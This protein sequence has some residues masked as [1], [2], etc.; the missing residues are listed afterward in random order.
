MIKNKNFNNFFYLIQRILFFREIRISN[1]TNR[2]QFKLHL[3]VTNGEETIAL[4][5]VR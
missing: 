4:E 2:E 3:K 5:L 1:K